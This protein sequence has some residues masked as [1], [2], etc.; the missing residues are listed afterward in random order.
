M[1]RV[2]DSGVDIFLLEKGVIGQNLIKAS[3]SGQ[4]LKN[5]IDTNK[6]TLLQD[7]FDL[8]VTTL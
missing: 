1:R 6:D 3:A 7:L 4:K 8:D 5:F 2:L